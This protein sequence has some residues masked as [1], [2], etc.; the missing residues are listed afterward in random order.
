MVVPLL[1]LVLS[2]AVLGSAMSGDAPVS[3]RERDKI[4]RQ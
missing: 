2:E 4:V 1:L 3:L